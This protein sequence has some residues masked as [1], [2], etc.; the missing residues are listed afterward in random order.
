[1][2]SLGIE[3]DNYTG[4]KLREVTYFTCLRL[5]AESVAKLPLKLYQDDIANGGSKEVTNYV[6]RML[7]FRPNPYMT[8]S[9]FWQTVE[10]NRNHYGNAYVWMQINKTTGRVE[11]FWV[12]PSDAVQVWVDDRGIFG[13]QNAI[14]Y[15][16]TEKSR[17]YKLHFDEVLHFKTSVTLDG[18][19]GL[20]VK[21]ILSLTVDNAMRASSHLHN[22][23]KSGLT[24]ASVLYYTGNLDFKNARTLRNKIEDFAAG[25]KNAGKVIPLPLGFQM[26]PL[27]IKFSD[28]QFIEITKYNAVQ[29]AAAFGIKRYML[30]DDSSDAAKSVE[31]QQRSFHIDTALA[32]LKNYEEELSFKTLTTKE[33][34]A[35]FRFK[36]NANG[37]LRADFATQMTGLAQGVNN[38]I[39]T[40]NEARAWL[41]LPKHPD[42]DNLVA[43]GN[44]IQLK[45]VFEKKEEAPILPPPEIT[46][47]EPEE[48][49]EEGGEE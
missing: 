18:I 48:E 49:Q 26:T 17:Q 8:A 35:G 36:F 2:R 19:L 38:A 30:N 10:M 45:D 15:I 32:I 9:T 25:P 4:D 16:Y 31:A 21:D 34:G 13:K 42:G 22:T 27:N 28:M 20:S 41:D 33:Q 14:W 23:F 44:Y 46:E 5:L 40:P 11:G 3:P 1:M 39:L 47:E 29:I 37:V 24:A 43:N 12:M 6:H 7:K